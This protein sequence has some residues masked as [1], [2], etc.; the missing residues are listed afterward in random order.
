MFAKK[1]SERFCIFKDRFLK[2][3][4]TMPNSSAFL[5]VFP[6]NIDFKDCSRKKS[7]S[8]TFKHLYEPCYCINRQGEMLMFY[9]CLKIEIKYQNK[10]FLLF[11]PYS[12]SKKT[13]SL[14]FNTQ[15][16]HIISMDLLI[17]QNSHR[18]IFM[19]IH[20]LFIDFRYTEM[21]L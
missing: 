6:E 1:N 13:T 14:I 20:C 9:R 21:Y 12:F 3:Q 4:D 11:V 8:R 15:S 10:Y 17:H 18:T 5:G 19:I 7:N 16:K 2:F